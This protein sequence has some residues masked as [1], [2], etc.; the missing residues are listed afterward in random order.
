MQ[1]A[2]NFLLL[3]PFGVYLRY[4]FQKK[5]YWKMAFGLGFVLSLFYEITQITGIYG[6]YNCAYRILDVD[7]LILN[8][9]GALFGFLVAPV[10][11][12]L[13]PSRKSL[14]AKSEKMR[15]SHFVPPLS[16][17]VAITIDYLLIKVSWILIVRLFPTNGF[18][19]F[20]YTTFG[21]IILYFLVP[22]IW[23]GK[24]IG[25][26]IMR[27]KLIKSGGEPPSWQSLLKRFFALYLPW[28]VSWS[29]NLFNSI[30]LDMDSN[31]YPYHVWTTVAIFAFL[32][33]MWIV[34]FI[35]VMFI[36]I[37]RGKRNFYFDYVADL[38]PRR[39]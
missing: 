24:T 21:F 23:N 15:E 26:N 1:A 13:F 27:F 6:I 33:I 9:T 5:R 34:L 16:Q 29:L 38:V 31:L 7:D 18:L 4:F 22:L 36:L 39:K 17:L 32:V 19:A 8:S 30:Q 3:L 35:H 20:T 10:I 14:L 37:S 2:F 25:T 12:A 11:L 28:T